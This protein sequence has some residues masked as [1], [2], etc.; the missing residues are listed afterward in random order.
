MFGNH[1]SVLA[2][3]ID[4]LLVVVIFNEMG[5]FLSWSIYSLVVAVVFFF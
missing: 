1:R 2:R 3:H 4:P 5:S